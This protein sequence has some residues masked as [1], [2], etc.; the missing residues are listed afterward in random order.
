MQ[1]LPSQLYN[2]A[3]VVQLEQLAIN[4]HGI[5]AY[6]L[7]QRAGKAVYEAVKNHYS[8]CKNI[9]VLC[10]AGNN[11]G[12]GYVVA[13][14]LRL[15]DYDV[16]VVSL[17]DPEKLKNEARQ[18]YLDW[19]EVGHNYHADRAYIE[20]ADIIVDALLGTGLQRK[21]SGSWAQWIEAVN[22]ARKPV[23]SVDIPS[24]L[25]ADTGIIAGAAIQAEYTVSFIG[26]K[27]GLFTAQGR[28]VC[29]EI[30]FDDLDVPHEL[31]AR[32]APQAHLLKAVDYD[33]LPERRASSHKGSFGHVLIAGGNEGMPGAVILAAR[34]ALRTGAGLVTIV[35]HEKNLAAI[36][37]AVPEAMVKAA[38]DEN[39]P[40]L[41][42]ALAQKVTHIA[43][44]M[45]LGQDGWSYQ[46]LRHC[47]KLNKPLVIDADGL[48]CLAQAQLEISSPFV[49]TPHPGEAAR[50]LSTGSKEL[51][52]AE[53]Q[54]NRFQA[55]RDLYA[56]SAH[57][58]RPGITHTVVLKG[59][60]TLLFNGSETAVC[61]LGSAAM[62]APG[63][64]DVL[65][66]I[67]SALMAQGL[68][69][70]R[71]ARLGVCLHAAAADSLTADKTRGLLASD[72]VDVL[73]GLMQ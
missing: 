38:G 42:K 69:T 25:Y 51:S 43:V 59:S 31:Y 14:L 67:I 56:L 44:G 72:V 8:R 11:A 23:V 10:G 1:N 5:P 55:V 2:V 40:D 29:G 66:G 26:L 17:S 65:S 13:R 7:M 39:M 9:L 73:R 61:A 47:L 4:E 35:T 45:G 20:K 54:A 49:M 32:V 28:D 62:A 34:A 3:S 60:G 21:V 41:F 33:L 52:A 30:L 63:M 36:C 64:G 12:D 16:S 22:D 37:T 70:D 6:T 68:D 27:Q 46:V 19:C 18:A 71:A 50:L 57:R 48:N 24:G 53:I 58:A 15:A